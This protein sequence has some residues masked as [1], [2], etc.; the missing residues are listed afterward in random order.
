MTEN[1]NS[2][3]FNSL[4][5]IVITLFTIVGFFVCVLFIINL[6]TKYFYKYH[7]LTEKWYVIHFAPSKIVQELPNMIDL[8]N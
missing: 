6:Y 4:S 1:N 8:N 3:F 2:G 5:N 7:Y